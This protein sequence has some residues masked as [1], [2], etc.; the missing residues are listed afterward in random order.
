MVR[1][2]LFLRL[3]LLRAAVR[4]WKSTTG[5]CPHPRDSRCPARGTA[6]QPCQPAISRYFRHFKRTLEKTSLVV[7]V[8]GYITQ[9]EH[10]AP[11]NEAYITYFPSGLPART[12]VVTGMLDKAGNIEIEM[13]ALHAR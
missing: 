11:M 6:A 5:R 1:S 10:F 12:T 8:N 2:M 3:A 7:K 13:I 4:P 9:I